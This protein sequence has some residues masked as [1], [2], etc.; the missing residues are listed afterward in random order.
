MWSTVVTDDMSDVDLD[1]DENSE[2]ILVHKQPSWR[3]VNLTNIICELDD[4]K[5]SEETPRRVI[6]LVS[7]RKRSGQA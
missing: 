1:V 6:G 2:K 3:D 4:L 5:R 7:E